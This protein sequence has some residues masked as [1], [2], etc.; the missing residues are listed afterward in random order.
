MSDKKDLSVKVIT[1]ANAGSCSAYELRQELIRREAFDLEEEKVNFRSLLQRLMVELVKD[2]EAL[3][4]QRL[5]E[6]EESA[7]AKREEAKKERE[8]KKAEA[9]ERS[10][11]RQADP[12]YLQSRQ[13]ASTL[14]SGSSTPVIAAVGVV[15]E[16]KKDDSVTEEG[17]GSGE[18]RQ[19]G[20]EEE[21]DVFRA[22]KSKSRNKVYV[23]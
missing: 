7:A 21:E 2:E 18:D 11:Q 9:L 12:A 5:K 4:A 23:K 17:K 16:V 14:A 15:D 20:E 10:R 19:K 22:Y 13:T 3:Q 6:Q 8:R 1:V